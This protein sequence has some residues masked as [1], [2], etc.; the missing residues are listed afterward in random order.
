MTDQRQRGALG[1]VNQLVG[2]FDRERDRQGGE[3][4]LSASS[5]THGAMVRRERRSRPT[6]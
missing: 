1:A 5:E 2:Q 3:G 6:I 4:R